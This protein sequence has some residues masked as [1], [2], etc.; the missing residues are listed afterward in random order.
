MKQKVL[1][2][3]GPLV[4]ILSLSDTHH[5]RCI[6]TLQTL[7]P[8]L[9]TC[10]SVITETHWLIRKN[11]VAVTSLFKMI[12]GG[13]IEVV[14]LPEESIPWL[15]IFILKYHDIGVQIA[16]ASLCYLA[17]I[18]H[19]DTIFTLDR[20]DFSIYRIRNNQTLKIIPE[21]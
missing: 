10:W 1:V 18:R 5:Q 20:R 16:D 14:H 8:P 12:E 6:T 13:L 9:L 15:K 19:L 4:S 17:E 2:D 11:K 21:F 7:Q 3:T